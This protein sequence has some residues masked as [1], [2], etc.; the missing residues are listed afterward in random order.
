MKVNFNEF[1]YL[2]IFFF[3]KKIVI[4]RMILKILLNKKGI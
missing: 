2:F 1:I 4:N 3:Y